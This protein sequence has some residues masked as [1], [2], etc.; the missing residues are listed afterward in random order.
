MLRW[1]RC[2]QVVRLRPGFINAQVVIAASLAYLGRLDEAREHLSR[3][4][5]IDPRYQQPPWLRPEDNALRVEG[6]RLAAGE[7]K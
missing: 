2:S 4:H 1:R 6:V 3:V 5:F 7:V